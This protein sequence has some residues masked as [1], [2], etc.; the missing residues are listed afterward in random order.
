MRLAQP[1][2]ARPGVTGEGGMHPVQAPQAASCQ[3]A[4][5]CT[6]GVWSVVWARGASHGVSSFCARCSSERIEVVYLILQRPGS[7]AFWEPRH[8]GS[9][10]L[11]L[12][13]CICAQGVSKESFFVSIRQLPLS[14]NVQSPLKFWFLNNTS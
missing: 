2:R 8:S 4:L 13:P 7:L 1:T 11:V 12:G 6:P 5:V 9:F 3:P 10:H 14:S